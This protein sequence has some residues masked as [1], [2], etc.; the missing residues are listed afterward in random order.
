MQRQEIKAYTRL[1][2]ESTCWHQ[3]KGGQSAGQD[4]AFGDLTLSSA[5]GMWQG[6]Q[7]GD[8]AQGILAQATGVAV[9]L[10]RAQGHAPNET[11]PIAVIRFKRQE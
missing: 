4:L 8:Q 11:T 5:Q 6:C 10:S 7:L 2:L 9:Q 1:G 3:V